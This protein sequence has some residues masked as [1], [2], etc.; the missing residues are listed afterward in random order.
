MIR[1]SITELKNRLS[2]YLRLVRRGETIEI[3]DRSQPVARVSRV[4]TE[5]A[6]TGALDQLIAR[7]LV[8]A[9]TE[10]P[11]AD[12]FS[13]RPLV[14]CDGDAIQAVIDERGDW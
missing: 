4:S 14:P 2:H 8:K 6:A 7:G 3:L 10:A 13:E 1:V 9:P 11:D 12:F 5:G